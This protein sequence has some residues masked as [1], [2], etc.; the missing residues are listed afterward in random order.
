[1]QFRRLGASGLRVSAIGLG[2]NPFGN[3]VDAA[4]AR[5]IVERALEAGVTYFDTADSYYEGRSETY[6]GQ[7][8]EDLGARQ[9]VVL[10][11]KFGNRVGAG[12]NDAGA[13]R[14]HILASCE[15][16]LRR[17]RT[18]AIDLYQVH[19]PDRDTPIEETLEALTSLVRQG[20]VRYVG[21]S[22]YFEW[23]V[24]EAIWLA[25]ERGLR[26]FVTCQD[27]YNLLYRD[28][29]KRFVPMCL[30]YGLGLIPY[31]PLAGALLSGTYRRGETPPAGSRGALRP[32]FRF[33][34]SD[35]N[36]RVQEALTTFAEQRG[37]SLPRLAIAWLLS[38]PGVPTVIAGADQPEHVQ[39]NVG[40]LDISLT[41]ADLGE[42]DRLTLVDED[43][44]VAPVPLSK[45]LLAI[46]SHDGYAA[47][48]SGTNLAPRPQSMS[49]GAP[50]APARA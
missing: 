9:Q 4:M 35:R 31:L 21:C 47:L 37:W 10:A 29:E 2:C 41:D 39:H 6:L 36:W 26:A 1:V 27:F 5:Q 38:R 14:H 46:E 34:D 30:K 23:E 8:L 43:R 45:G 32:T 28:V 44:S 17:L 24:V 49:L 11:T 18:D 16:S 12:P 7:A 19:T 13:S 42:I 22:N 33:W 48:L 3:E 15:A 20:K 25:R 40:A 50:L